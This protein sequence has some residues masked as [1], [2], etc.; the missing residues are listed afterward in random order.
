MSQHD[1][2]VVDA[3]ATNSASW[4]SVEMRVRQDFGTPDP[5][6]AKKTEYHTAEDHY[7]ETVVGQRLTEITYSEGKDVHYSSSSYSDGSR[8]ADVEFDVDEPDHQQSVTIKRSFYM[9]GQSGKVDRP[10]PLLFLYV[11]RKPLL[12]ALPSAKP[13]GA[14]VHMGRPCEDY[15]FEKIAWMVT[16]DMIYSLDRQTGLPLHVIS[17]P[18]AQGRSHD[19]PFWEWTAESLDQV[20]GFYLV[21]NSRQT[22]FDRRGVINPTAPHRTVLFDRKFQ[23]QS[24][25]FNK[26]FPAMTFW[27]KIQPGVSVMDTTTKKVYKEPGTPLPSAR[28]QG[29]QPT[30]TVP[31]VATPPP[32]WTATGTTV[33]LGLSVT[34]VVLGIFLRFRRG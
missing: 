3:L 31:L 10:I 34:L 17:F 24:V 23:V 26:S 22:D 29:D 28:R 7:V 15:L 33:V 20:G 11:G 21:K 13:L 2:S 4:Q 27:P 1:P 25:E 16:Q 32:A 12:E 30:A 8:F 5:E 9:E 6:L 18:D 19:Q 14:S